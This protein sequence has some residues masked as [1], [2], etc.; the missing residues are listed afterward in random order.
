VRLRAAR[1][2]ET[3]E[4]TTVPS[5]PLLLGA[6]FVPAVPTDG[7]GVWRTLEIAV[8]PERIYA[9]R[10]GVLVGELPTPQLVEAMNGR[11]QDLRRNQH[12]T[13]EFKSPAWQPR[14]ALGFC[15]ER[16]S[17]SVR[18]VTVTALSHAAICAVD[19]F[20]RNCSGVN[21]STSHQRIP[22]GHGTPSRW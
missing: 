9:S 2:D 4:G 8:T 18:N 12:T 11:R 21:L 13:I 14:G 17:A 19:S 6:A 20:A 1:Y 7:T 5:M 10:D 3:T 16:A 15:L 22:G